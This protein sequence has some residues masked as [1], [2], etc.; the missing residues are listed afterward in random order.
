MKT[1]EASNFVLECLET[2]T[3]IKF[4]VTA[5]KGCKHLEELL[6]KVYVLYADFVAKNPFQTLDNVIKCSL[7]DTHLSLYL[8]SHWGDGDGGYAPPTVKR[9]RR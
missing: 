3:G 1:L 2:P 9:G 6:A 4:F 8:K 7:F 5:T